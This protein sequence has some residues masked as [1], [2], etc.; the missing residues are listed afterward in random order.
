MEELGQEVTAL[1]EETDVEEFDERVAAETET[2]KAELEVGTFDNPQAI[3]GLEYEF[4]GVDDTSGALRRVPRALLNLI[5]FEKEL[6]LHNAE[7]TASPHPLG[8]HGLAAVQNGVQSAVWAAHAASTRCEQ[9]Q[10]V[11]DGFWSIPPTGETAA[12]YLATDRELGEFVLAENMSHSVRYHAMSS[13]PTYEPGRRIDTANASLSSR[14][15]MPVALTTSIQPHY[16]MPIAAEL[17]TYFRYAV[18][19]AGPLVALAVNSPLFPPSLYDDDATVGSVLS[20]GRREN[21]VFVFESVLNDP[22]RPDKVRFPRDVEE[23][24]EAVDRLAEDPPIVPQCR[25]DDHRFDDQFVHLR[26]KHGSYW[27]WVRPVF[28]G[29]SK[30][31]ANARIEFRPL[32]AQPTVRDSVSLLATVAGA[33]RAFVHTD[34]PVSTQPW[35]TARENFYA[36]VHDGLDAD[37]QW[38]TAHGQETTDTD[39]IYADLFDH[40]RQGLELQGFGTDTAEEYLR[41]LRQRIERETTPADW[42]LERLRHHAGQGHTLAGAIAAAKRDYLREQS[43]TLVDGTFTEWTDF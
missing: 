24:A 40:A 31:E 29:A 8:P 5:G 3:I 23:T 21:R 34:H 9:I 2:L 10:L 37:L 35:E 33:L 15:V 43:D 28:E 30:A 25:D 6:G 36:A 4:Y 27:R 42:K 39:A 19:L 13:A 26:H 7:F 32:P 1:L 17:P 22:E 38:I 11:S 14:S 18:R 41:P 12:G 16:Q 20:E